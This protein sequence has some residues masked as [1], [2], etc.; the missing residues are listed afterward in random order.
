MF[1]SFLSFIFDFL[2][3]LL[4]LRPDWCWSHFIKSCYNEAF[5]FRFLSF[6]CL[7]PKCLLCRLI[8]PVIIL[9]FCL[10]MT[11][12]L[13]CIFMSLCNCARVYPSHKN[14]GTTFFVTGVF[15]CID[16]YIHIILYR[17]FIDATLSH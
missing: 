4:S 3:V 10:L 16:L 7:K 6:H 11:Y 15:Y 2:T 5:T 9:F 12:T 13:Y 14:Q 8:V 1:V 17:M